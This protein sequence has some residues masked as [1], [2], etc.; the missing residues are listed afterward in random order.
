MNFQTVDKTWRKILDNAFK[1]N[2]A[3]KYC[4]SEKLLEE[5]RVANKNLARVQRGLNDYL[6]SKRVSF[7]R[8]YF[9]SDDEL[10]SILSQTKDPTAVQRHLRRCFEN[11]G[12]LKFEDDLRITQMISCEGEVVPLL[13]T[14]YPEGNVEFWLLDV[15]ASMRETLKDISSRSFEEYAKIARTEW[16]FKLAS[17]NYSSC[18]NDLL[19]KI[20]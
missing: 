9:L 11:V 5:F 12:M 10:L 1:N 15:E 7:P 8:F 4:P 16:V 20:S 3:L 2:R 18:C 13:R 19:D 14:F 6:E 17:T